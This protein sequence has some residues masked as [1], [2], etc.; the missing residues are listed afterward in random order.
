MF[1]GG[2]LANEIIDNE[3]AKVPIVVFSQIEKNNDIVKE[4]LNAGINK[5]LEKGCITPERFKEKIFGIIDLPI[6]ETSSITGDPY[7]IGREF[8]VKIETENINTIKIP[9]DNRLSPND[10][11][12]EQEL[13]IKLDN[14]NLFNISQ[15]ISGKISSNLLQVLQSELAS[16]ISNTI[17]NNHCESKT[18]S[19]KTTLR[20]KAGEYLIYEITCK[21]KIRRSKFE[22]LVNGHSIIIP[23]TAY[24]DIEYA[25]KGEPIEDKP[26]SISPVLKKNR[27]TFG[28][29]VTEKLKFVELNDE[30][31]NLIK[32]IFEDVNAGKRNHEDER[33][34]INGIIY[35]LITKCKWK[36]IPT[37]YNHNQSGSTNYK[38]RKWKKN[39]IW[40]RILEAAQKQGY[41]IEALRQ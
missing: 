27:K 21:R 17:G 38:F 30:Q 10:L 7:V 15:E 12:I 41:E 26:E 11:E 33:N 36:N 16:K 2:I 9:L 1:H 25:V 18:V 20:A 14:N 28:Y 13:S 34:L 40:N 22:V 29:V 19:N 4:L 37:R 39:G 32:P 8:D 35:V 3:V 5:F 31:W 23:S 24:Y 6:S